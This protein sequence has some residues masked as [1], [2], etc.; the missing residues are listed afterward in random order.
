MTTAAPVPLVALLT[1]V[2]DPRRPQGQHH[3]LKAILLI[4]TLAIICGADHWT[5]VEFFGHKKQAW[6]EN[7]LELPH[8]IPSHDPLLQRR[9]QRLHPSRET[10]FS[11][12]APRPAGRPGRPARVAAWGPC[13]GPTPGGGRPPPDGP[14][15]KR[16][17]PGP[18]GRGPEP[19]ARRGRWTWDDSQGGTE[20]R[21]SYPIFTTVVLEQQHAGKAR[22]PFSAVWE[23]VV[24]PIAGGPAGRAARVRTPRGRPTFR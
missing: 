6:L 13:P 5:E 23:G 9:C 14:A 11:C 12:A 4:A 15:R 7:F 21:P 16:S 20:V 10:G 17:W 8:G 24:H 19:E 3:S 2:D 22:F 1:A 18:R